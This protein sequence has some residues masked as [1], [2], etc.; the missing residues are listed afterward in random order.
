[1]RM[2][3]G[4]VIVENSMETPQKFKNRNT[5]WSSNSTT[6]YLPKENKST[7]LKIYMHP[8]SIATLFLKNILFI[9]LR[10]R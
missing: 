10:E 5:I 8:M 4:A 9:Y 2:Q 1:M 3:I 6:E 7:H